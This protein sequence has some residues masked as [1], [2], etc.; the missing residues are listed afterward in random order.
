MIKGRIHP[1]YRCSAD[2][3]L[4]GPV[5]HFRHQGSLNQ[6]NVNKNVWLDHIRRSVGSWEL[7]SSLLNNHHHDR[8]KSVWRDSGKKY[9]HASFKVLS[10]SSLLPCFLA[11]W[12][13]TLRYS[14]VKATGDGM[15][16]TVTFSWLGISLDLNI[17][18]NIW[19]NVST[20]RSK[21]NNKK[22]RNL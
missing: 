21:I 20:R 19:D 13:I 1:K 9:S 7:L 4:K 8:W 5:C 14:E 18:G 10:M 11:L 16:H 6:N 15:K 17:A 2:F 3:S 22:S 12:P